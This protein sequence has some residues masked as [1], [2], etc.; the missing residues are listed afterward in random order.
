MK[1]IV[2]LLGVVCG[3]FIIS[4]C[5]NNNKTK[6]TTSSTK[7]EYADKAFI[8]DFKQGLY[9]RWDYQ[10][11]SKSDKDYYSDI[12][13]YYKKLA[14]KELNSIEKYKNENFKDSQLHEYAL[15]YINN[16]KKS[17]TLK[18]TDYYAFDNSGDDVTDYASYGAEAYGNIY[19]KRIVLIRNIVKKYNIEVDKKYKK[20]LTN[21]LD[22]A[23]IAD[24]KQ[25]EVDSVNGMFKNV[26]FAKN[27]NNEGEYTAIV[28]NT[29]NY[30]FNNILCEYR[31]LLADDT[32]IGTQYVSV[33]KWAPHQKYTISMY[34]NDSFDKTELMKCD[35]E[36]EQ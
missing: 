33:Q 26:T 29:T 30:T 14:D 11:S 4:G 6:S 27:P 19:N 22:N 12:K 16:L 18:A 28:E 25:Q 17:K 31:L 13:T 2:L 34:T 24:K 35:Y 10:D 23:K 21:V 7:E 1:K 8:K 32:V 15:S 9:D 5:G 36:I 3:L 20:S